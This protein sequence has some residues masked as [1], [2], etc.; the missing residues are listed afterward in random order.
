MVVATTDHPPTGGQPRPTP[1]RTWTAPEP[2]GTGLADPLP[3]DDDPSCTN[4]RG[5]P[6]P[7]HPTGDISTEPQWGDGESPTPSVTP[8][9]SQ[10]PT[11][12]PTLSS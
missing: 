7:C 6:P 10:T 3:P 2:E 4:S 9:L 8:T 1:A 12:T 5:G 11:P